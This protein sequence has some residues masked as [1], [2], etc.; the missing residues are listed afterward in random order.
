MSVNT[1]KGLRFHGDIGAFERR[2]VGSL[3]GN[4]GN[5][6]ISLGIVHQ[7]VA[8]V[9][10]VLADQNIGYSTGLTSQ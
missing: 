8:G 5:D 3:I 6:H 4:A 10:F 9:N 7:G 2:S 1:V